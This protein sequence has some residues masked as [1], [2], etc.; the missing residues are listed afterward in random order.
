[1]SLASL[2]NGPASSRQ[3]RRRMRAGSASGP[4]ALS[5]RKAARCWRALRARSARKSPSSMSGSARTENS[6]RSAAVE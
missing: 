5:A 1:M 6:S 3:H 4:V 2:Q